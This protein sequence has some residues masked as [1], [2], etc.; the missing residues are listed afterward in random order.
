MRHKILR[1]RDRVDVAMLSLMRVSNKGI[2]VEVNT[3][4]KDQGIEGFRVLT[5]GK[6]KQTWISMIMLNSKAYSRGVLANSCHLLM[7]Y[8]SIFYNIHQ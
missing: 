2:R 5:Q 1:G 6:L 7:Q 8:T 3:I 4:L